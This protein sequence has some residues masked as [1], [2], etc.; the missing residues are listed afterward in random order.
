MPGGRRPWRRA[1]GAR[2]AGGGLAEPRAQPDRTAGRRHARRA[3]RRPLPGSRRR[4]HRDR[5]RHGRAGLGGDRARRRGGRSGG[6]RE[7]GPRRQVRGGAAGPAA[8][9]ER[10]L[11]PDGEGRERRAVEDRDRGVAAGRRQ[12]RP[13]SAGDVRVPARDRTPPTAILLLRSGGRVVSSDGASARGPGPADSAGRAVSRSHRADPRPR[14]RDRPDS[15]VADVPAALPRPGRRPRGGR[16]PGAPLPSGRD[17][18]RPAAA[19]GAGPERAHAP[20]AGAPRAPPAA[21]SCMAR[22]GRTQP[23]R[24]GSRASATRS[25]SSWA[26]DRE[27]YVDRL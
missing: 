17:R 21:V 5:D 25:G 16:A 19:R 11:S 18:P 9:R 26:T 4:R 27:R 24:P 14:R 1:H 8:P 6:S 10:D 13:R 2:T 12:G 22:P 3:R 23:T 15:G 20:S 7:R